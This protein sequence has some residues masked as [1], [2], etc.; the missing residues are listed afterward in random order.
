[1]PATLKFSLVL[2]TLGR[3]EE[4]ARF[5]AHLEQQTYR[6]FELIIVDQNPPGVLDSLIHQFINKFPLLHLRSE[7]GLSRARNAGLQFANGDI[8]GF[9]DDDCWY[10]SDTLEDV[11]NEFHIRSECDGITARAADN[12]RP[13]SFVW[14]SRESGWISKKNV[15]RRAISFTIFLRASL[16][17]DTGKFDESLGV[18]SEN[19]RLSAEET[20]YLIR[21]VEIKKNIYYCS[22]LLVFHR[23]PIREYNKQVIK[24]VYGYSFGFGYVLRKHDYPFTFVLYYWMRAL[25][26]SVLS[27]F[28]FEFLKSKYYFAI[29]KGRILG[30]LD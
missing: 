4:L 6:D 25:C 7:R 30:W 27:L 8:V 15:W 10:A 5:L 12:I 9:P 23:D 26:A 3:T 22:S 11:A 1:M 29:F 24:R 21:A 14:F 13:D 2:A 28:S 16:I 20:D 18:G 19:G 17:N